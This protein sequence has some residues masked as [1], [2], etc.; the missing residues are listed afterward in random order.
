MA[1]S[2]KKPD[3]D[4]KPL[5]TQ[6]MGSDY[7]KHLSA[8]VVTGSIN[9][10]KKT[11]AGTQ[12]QSTTQVP[13]HK[14]LVDGGSKVGCSGARTINLG[15]YESVKFSVWLEMPCTKDTLAETYDFVTDWVGEQLT[16]A[17]A[18]AKG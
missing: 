12:L 2:I 14:G 3:G 9:V 6:S 5:H 11:Q 4:V 16:A 8:K 15:N 18:Q 17:V 7:G 13:V 10:E 1:I